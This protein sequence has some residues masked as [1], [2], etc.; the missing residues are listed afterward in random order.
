MPAATSIMAKKKPIQSEPELPQKPR[1][2]R[3][4]GEGRITSR[5]AIVATP[6]YKVWMEAFLAHVGETEVSDAFREGIRRYAE[7]TGF[8]SPPKR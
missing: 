6:E 2:G 8:R 7:A 1:K 4:K 5:F 3:P